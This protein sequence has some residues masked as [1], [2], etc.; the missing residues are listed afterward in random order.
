MQALFSILLRTPPGQEEMRGLRVLVSNSILRGQYFNL[1][2][3]F[4]G[5]CEIVFISSNTKVE[6]N[7]ETLRSSLNA[8]KNVDGGAEAGFATTKWRGSN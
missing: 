1:F 5:L 7:E 2:M 8:L 3:L 6:T 4:L